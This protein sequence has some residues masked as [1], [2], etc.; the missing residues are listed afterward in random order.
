M[1][2]SFINNFFLTNFIKLIPKS[3]IKK[4]RKRYNLITFIPTKLDY[5]PKENYPV[6]HNVAQQEKYI[7]NFYNLKR[8]TS[9]MTCPYLTQLLITI[10]EENFKL[11]FLDIGGEN[12]DFFLELKSKFK[13]LQY[14]IY[15][16]KKIL[17]N[18]EEL[19][20]K[21]FLEDFYIISD[22]KNIYNNKFEFINLGSCIQY[23]HIFDK[24]INL[25]IKVSNGGSGGHIF[26]SG[27]NVFT[28]NN[29]K[30]NFFVV[31]QI[32]FL[33]KTFYCYFFE[34]DFFFNFFKKKNYEILFEKI[35][36]T[37][38]INYD[39]FKQLAKDFRYIDVLFVNKPKIRN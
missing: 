2:Y 15:N 34:K 29:N 22:L 18:L 10:Y 35:N 24:I 12:I 11:R 33:P 14:Y 19:K 20:K 26:F 27:L 28:S 30:N 23:F 21:Y 39:N 6:N 25:I 1:D 37:D 3:I 38:K 4:I 32:N 8:R 5:L 16:Q 9:Q 7:K 36:L 31:K 13:N 17:E